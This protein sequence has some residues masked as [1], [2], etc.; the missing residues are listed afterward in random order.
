MGKS[1]EFENNFAVLLIAVP[2]EI[3]NSKLYVAC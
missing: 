3:S 1:C 2:S